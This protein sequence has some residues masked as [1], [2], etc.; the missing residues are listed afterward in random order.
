M[1]RILAR[2]V[3][4]IVVELTSPG[5]FAAFVPRRHAFTWGACGPAGI[6]CTSIQYF[7]I[8]GGSQSI[9][10]TF[11]PESFANPALRFVMK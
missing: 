4:R 9:I 5:S 2:I 6:P 8:S 10:P 1:V 7:R 11:A 3:V